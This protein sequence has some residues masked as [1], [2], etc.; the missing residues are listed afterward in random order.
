MSHR[1]WSDAKTTVPG[2]LPRP[3]PFDLHNALAFPV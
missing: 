2:N 1:P 3:S